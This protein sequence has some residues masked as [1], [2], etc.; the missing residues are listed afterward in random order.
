MRNQEDPTNGISLNTSSETHEQ[1][2][3][4]REL[5][6]SLLGIVKLIFLLTIV[7]LSFESLHQLLNTNQVRM[8]PYRNPKKAAK[9]FRKPKKVLVPIRKTV[10]SRAPRATRGWFNQPGEL[11]YVDVSAATYA[12]DTTGTVTALNLIAQGDDNTTR[13]GRQCFMKSIHV[14]GII[15][16]VDN[17]CSGGYC[18]VML[19]WDSQPNSGSIAT[20][21]DILTAATSL[22]ST[23]L[24]NRER[25][26][27]L[28]DC[29]YVIGGVSDTA[30]QAITL[31]PN[32]HMINEF[33]N[34]KM[35]KTTYSGTTATIGAVATGALLLV[36]IGNQVANSG[37]A[38][39]LTTRLRFYDF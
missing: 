15:R 39:D 3:P 12:C 28:R 25:F 14:Q 38:A 1:K 37:G 7:V 29:R 13:E 36:T 8:P 20:I 9:S 21:T 6:L 5:F 26:T 24:N 18:R 11:K 10:R 34:L 31:S 19:V 17:S 33:V 4:K 2:C 23:N 32:N 35:Q 27:I 22:A 30:T 16:P